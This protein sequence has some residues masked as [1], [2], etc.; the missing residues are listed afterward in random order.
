MATALTTAPTMT[1]NMALNSAP[2]TPPALPQS[3]SPAG[4]DGANAAAAG[5]QLARLRGSADALAGFLH[6]PVSLRVEVP[7]VALTVGDLFRLEKGSIVSTGQLTGA[8]VPLRVGGRLLAWGEFQ[9]IGEHLAVR[10][11]ELA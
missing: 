8:N 9:V 1:P 3:K 5:T 7:V 6:V 4:G 11:A 10:V 2:N